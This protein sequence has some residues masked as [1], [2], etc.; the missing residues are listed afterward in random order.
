[1]AE[2]KFILSENQ[3]TKL[4]ALIRQVEEGD[5]KIQLRDNPT[6]TVYNAW[7][8]NV[9]REHESLKGLS[10]SVAKLK[11]ISTLAET[12]FYFCDWFKVKVAGEKLFAAVGE[13]GL[14]LIN[15]R[16]PQAFKEL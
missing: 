11:F 3:L 9:R 16:C 2:E 4:H 6:E 14:T 7:E 15:R 13:K 10:P 8:L 12:E 1:M 5:S